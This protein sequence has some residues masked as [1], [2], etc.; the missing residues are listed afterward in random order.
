MGHQRMGRL[1]RTRQWRAV[2]ELITA[3]ADPAKIAA[4]TT[5]A[6]ERSLKEASNNAVLRYAFYLLTQIPLAA[7]T[8]NFG[9][10]LQDLG[11]QVGD[12]PNLI[13]VGAAMLE[14]IDGV[15]CS[16]IRQ[17]DDVD[18][19]AS[20]VATESLVSIASRN[21]S[22]LFGTSYAANEALVSLRGLSTDRQFGVLAR[23]FFSRLIRSFLGY[24]L[25]R[26]LPEHVGANRRF[27]SIM[28]H[29]A[30]DEALE[31][32][33]REASLIMEKFACDWFSRTNYEGGI[34]LDK[35][36]GFVHVALAKITA[37][38]Q[39]RRIAHA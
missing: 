28:D 9:E 33:C 15:S 32:H 30:F 5:D 14:A 12:A 11:L 20:K 19:I 2:I 18:E 35:A 10:N 26:A 24:F 3:G 37:E 23:D 16:P 38:L 39:A 22:S 21:G 13:E 36:G 31:Q 4:S 17:R 25:S 27:Q 7:R 34:T 6:A 1:P 29:H 8:G